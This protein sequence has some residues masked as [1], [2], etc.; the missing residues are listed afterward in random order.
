MVRQLSCWSWIDIFFSPHCGPRRTVGPELDDLEDDQAARESPIRTELLA[1]LRKIRP[2]QDLAV[3]AVVRNEA[4][5][6]IEWIAHYRAIGVDH[7]F[8]Y[9]NDNDDGT[10]DVL[11][12]LSKTGRVTPIFTTAAKGV[13]VQFKNYEHA[14]TLLPELRLFKWVIVVDGD[15]FL[16]P[17]AKYDYHLPTLLAT[18]NE[19][20][21]AIVFPWKWRLW[22]RCFER[23]HGLLWERF[24]HAVGSDL[25]KPVVKM[26]HVVSL[27]DLHWP[28]LTPG[29]RI[30]DSAFAEIPGEIPY[31]RYQ[32]K[33][34]EGGWIDHYWGKSF[35]EFARKK[36]RGDSADVE[37]GHWRRQFEDYFQ[38]TSKLSNENYSP[39][40]IT[41]AERIEQE[42]L[43]IRR[44]C[45]YDQIRGAIE[46]YNRHHVQKIRADPDLRVIFDELIKQNP[47]R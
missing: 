25:F 27:R 23:T 9:T 43:Q 2:I 39:L 16:V 3:L 7:F 24:K 41:L 46:R 34:D 21:D 10:D 28:R 29:R 5:Y 38:W 37:G 17:S 12:W 11:S 15:E 40:P 6:L 13:N 30:C 45:G 32:N 35:E 47:I 18:A 4:P 26:N 14:V 8:I 42:L 22:E 36:F 19:D 20:I 1:A 31:S 33:S 44:R